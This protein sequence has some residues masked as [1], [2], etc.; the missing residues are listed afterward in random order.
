MHIATCGHEIDE[1]ISCLV[2]EG[3][4]F[5]DDLTYGTYCDQCVLLY[6]YAGQLKNKEL[7]KLIEGTKREENE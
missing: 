1:G 5:G 7:S 2:K 6:Y 4:L 3:L